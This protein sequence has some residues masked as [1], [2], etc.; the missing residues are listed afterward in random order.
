[1]SIPDFNLPQYET[2]L[3][4]LSEGT[5]IFFGA[6]VSKLAGYKLWNEVRDSMIE[7]F[8]NNRIAISKR[9]GSPLDRSFCE[10]FKKH[11][12]IVEAFDFLYVLDK[13]LFIKGIN[14]IFY[15]DEQ[16]SNNKIYSYLNRLNNGNNFFV[17]TNIDR[18]F[19]QFI[20][21]SD[22]LVAINPNLE[23]PVKLL[24]YIHGRI[25]RQDSWIFTREQ[26][27]KG[28]SI[29]DTPCMR[30]LINILDNYNVLFIGYGLREEDIKRAIS[31]TKKRKT[32]YWLEES[33][34][35]K[36]D[37]LKIR[38][39]TM[40]NIYNIHLIPYN[41]DE[42]GHEILMKTIAALYT[43]VNNKTKGLR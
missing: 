41:I 17:T 16:K 18:G 9:S 1:M 42:E 15:D 25:D 3:Y 12:D 11:E 2:L 7:F 39:T 30:F 34:R 27:N 36:E 40:K 24:N 37:Y 5:C 33:S 14:S 10:Y 28:Y 19:Q 26:Y 23:N 13:P 35:N 4:S 32:H 8:W 29:D 22:E 38:G 20:G 31:L 21:V 43:S 6:G